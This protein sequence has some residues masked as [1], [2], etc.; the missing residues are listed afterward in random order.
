MPEITM[1]P[2]HEVLLYCL[3]GLNLALVITTVV[4]AF[5]IL[6]RYYWHSGDL[7]ELA[8]D[9]AHEGKY[10]KKSIHGLT[11][12]AI[13]CGLLACVCAM[14]MFLLMGYQTISFSIPV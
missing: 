11:T 2:T 8:K 10:D 1:T 3:M 14:V 4:T 7:T 12:I 9:T 13:T 6:H 5:I